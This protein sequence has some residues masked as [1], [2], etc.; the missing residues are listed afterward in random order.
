MAQKQKV[1]LNFS[2]VDD[3]HFKAPLK[4]Y[5]TKIADDHFVINNDDLAIK[6][7]GK[8]PKEAAEMLKEQFIVLANDVMYKSKYAPLSERERKKVNI[9]KSICDIL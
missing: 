7:N 2:D 5:I 4:G 8:T 3:F 9:I 1:E 6:G